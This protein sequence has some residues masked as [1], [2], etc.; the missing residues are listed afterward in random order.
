M[1]RTQQMICTASGPIQA[2][3]LQPLLVLLRNL[4]ARRGQEEHLVVDFPHRAAHRVRQSAREVDQATLEIAVEAAQVEDD[5]LVGLQVVA[6]LLRVVE[7]ARLDDVYR[8]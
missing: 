4:D 8:R 6:E 2:A 5:G 1:R 7:A 3:R